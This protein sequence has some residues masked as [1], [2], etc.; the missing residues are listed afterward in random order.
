[1][2]TILDARADQ[3]VCRF[4]ATLATR[5]SRRRLAVGRAANGEPIVASR[6]PVS[7]TRCACEAA[8][9]PRRR[10]RGTGAV[11]AF[12]SILARR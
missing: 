10:A 2:E 6:E 3:S 5:P 9:A 7:A 1:M 4:V 11:L 8:P 12:H